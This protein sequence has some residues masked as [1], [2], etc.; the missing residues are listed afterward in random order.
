MS[1]TFKDMQ[2][3]VL[4]RATR[5][6]AGTQFD[7]AAKETINTSLFRVA[8]EALWR[9]LRRKTTFDTVTTYNEGSGAGEFTED[10]KDI[11]ITGATFHT[12]N[13]QPGRR[14]KLS[15][16]SKV[17][18]IKQITSETDITI[19]VI[20]DGDTVTDG[21][22]SILAQEEYNLPIQSSHRL[23]LWHERWGY[24]YSLTYVTDQ[25]FYNRSLFNTTESIPV[26][27]RMWGEDWVVEQVKEASVVQISSSETADTNIEVIVYGTVSG[28]PDFET[29]TT[30]SS[31]GTTAVNGSKAFSNIERVVKTAT[32]TGRITATANSTNTTVAVMPVGDTTA[33]IKYSKIQLF[34]LPS[35]VFPINV[36]YYKDPYR[37]V[38]DGA[39]QE[40]GQEFDE[41]IILLAV[42]KINF[43]SNKDEGSDFFAMYKDELRSLKKHN[44]DKIDWFPTLKSA[45]RR[46]LGRPHPFLG[47]GQVGPHFGR[48]T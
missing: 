6:E 42:A 27:Y 41:A 20:Y 23:F 2:N 9:P 12:D 22:Y 34:P 4:R 48:R 13:I 31:N 32:S 11:T 45:Y 14:I 38:A 18:V 46:G 39:I 30:N 28:Y 15:G 7:T 33:G 25:E 40:L 19:D 29:I 10:S 37:L 17:F 5:S 26:G 35:T 8:R 43:E 36:Q 24:P 1:M 3:S 47:Y 44:V 16:T 21:T